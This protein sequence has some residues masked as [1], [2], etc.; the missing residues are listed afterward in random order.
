MRRQGIH[1]VGHL[2]EGKD[3]VVHRT[4]RK[5]A[6]KELKRPD[7]YHR[8]LR[9]YQVLSDLSISEVG[10]F[11]VPRLIGFDDD[12]R[13][14]EMTIV[15]PPYFLD[16]ASTYDEVEMFR[17]DFSEEV[18]AEREAHWRD[19]FGLDWASVSTARDKFLQL[20]GLMHLDL[21]PKNIRSR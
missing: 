2:G 13:I 9:A 1:S 7:L 16:F 10:G 5:S 19:L 3:G 4:N 11:K 17:F 15:T 12:S 14:I 6:V 21:S 8:E 20:T 18:W